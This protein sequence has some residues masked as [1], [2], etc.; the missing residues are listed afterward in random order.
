MERRFEHIEDRFDVFEQ[1][2]NN[3]YSLNLKIRFD[4]YRFSDDGY[5]MHDDIVDELPLAGH[6]TVLDVGCGSGE[7]LYKLRT[8]IGHQGRLIGADLDKVSF[9]TEDKIRKFGAKPIEFIISEAANLELPDGSVDVLLS[10]FMLYH[11]KNPEKALREFQRVVRPGGEIWVATSGPGNKPKHR[12]IE[13]S[14]AK[15][16]DVKPPP[17]FSRRFSS[18]SAERKLSKY[19][20]YQR[21]VAQDEA[22]LEI[23]PDRIPNYLMSLGTMANACDPPVPERTWMQAIET[24]AL[25]RIQKEI[26]E[27]GVFLD[28]IE[29]HYWVYENRLENTVN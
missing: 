21:H 20:T 4:L 22:N 1:Y 13:S 28:P 12:E 14:A 17:V 7:L 3:P 10:L 18:L 26:D 15:L 23:T 9:L 25:P 8:E 11:V 24:V 27:Q 6:E 5:D 19:F 29:R 2:T 16:L